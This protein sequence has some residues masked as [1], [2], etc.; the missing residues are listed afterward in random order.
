MRILGLILFVAPLSAGL[1]ISNEPVCIIQGDESGVNRPEGIAFS[2]S[3]DCLAVANSAGYSVTV[4][5]RTEDENPIY[6]TTPTVHFQDSSVLRYPHSV[7][8]TPDGKHLAVASRDN[9]S[10]VLY[11]RNFSAI[12][13]FEMT[14]AA[15]LRGFGMNLPAGVSFSADADVMGVANRAG[16]QPL[17]FYRRYNGPVYY[18]QPFHSISREEVNQLG[19]S[20][21]H[22]LAFSPLGDSFTTLHKPYCRNSPGSSGFITYDNQ[23][24]IQSMSPHGIECLHSISYHPSGNYLAISHEREEVLIF[25][26]NGSEFVQIASI[27]I[28]KGE[29]I[30]GAKGVAFSPRGDALAV[31]T[32]LQTI[33]IFEIHE[34][35]E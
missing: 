10:V 35:E 25:E 19:M 21:A 7:E 18:D 3:G 29:S 5:R 1:T 13:S 6:S 16:N 15:I 9:H 2:P 34:T 26:K 14:P 31:T 22:D 4:Y 27:P 8:F 32:M 11:K 17:T 24:N 12:C 28:E 33:L 23:F 20:M 30:E